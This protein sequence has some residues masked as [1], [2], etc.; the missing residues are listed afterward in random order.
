MTPA[1]RRQTASDDPGRLRLADASPNAGHV[2][3]PLLS[4][5][6]LAAILKCSRRLLER[7][8]SAGKVPRP[9]FMVGRCPRWKRSTLAAWIETGG[10]S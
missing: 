7:M 6:D 8:R 9:D 5:D 4:L 2:I 10:R 3:E 1:S